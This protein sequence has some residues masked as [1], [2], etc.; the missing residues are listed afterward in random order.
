MT[1]NKTVSNNL[2]LQKVIKYRKVGMRW[3]HL[4]EVFKQ[5]S[6]QDTDKGVY[7]L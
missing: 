7:L 4:P 2:L 6:L 1:E 5:N 3:I